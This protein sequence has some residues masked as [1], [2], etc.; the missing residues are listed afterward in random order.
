MKERWG[1]AHIYSSLNNTIIHITDVTG[2]ETLAFVSGGMVCDRD[3][4]KGKPFTAMKAARKAAEKAMESGITNL[5]I[6]IRAIGGIKSKMPG[7]GA[8]PAVRALARAGF[9]IGSIEDVTPIPHNGCRK[10]GGR[11]GRRV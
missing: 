2:S 5:H 10:K 6:K 1:I 3:M 11:R 4:N 8:Q 7:Q 9:R